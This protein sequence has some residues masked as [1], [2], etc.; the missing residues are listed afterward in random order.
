LKGSKVRKKAKIFKLYRLTSLSRR[1]LELIGKGEVASSVADVLN[2]EKSTVS[3]HVKRFVKCD[4]LRLVV[5][6]RIKVYELTPLGSKVPAGSEREFE[7][8]VVL[9]DYPFKFS[10]VEPERFPIDWKK[11]G[12]P[13][14]WVKKGVKIGRITVEKH[15]DK[16]VVIHTGRIKGFDVN[17][18]L[19]EAGLVVSQV[20]GVLEYDFGLI[21]SDSGF[22]VGKPVVRFYDEV[23]KELNKYGAVSVEGVGSVDHS[24]PERVPHSEYRGVENVR[25]Y[26]LMPR[27]LANIESRIESLENNLNALSK[28]FDRFVE[29]FS[30]VSNLSDVANSGS[31]GKGHDKFMSYVS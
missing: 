4:L 28:S 5:C 3:Y 8:M 18:L 14:N 6:D 25:D 22:P 1:I 15:G 17:A 9:E 31:S 7:E 12:E 23:A 27:R 26:I 19:V 20:K 11:M 24:P 13:R 29:L 21:L 10:I 16:S 30:K 2:C